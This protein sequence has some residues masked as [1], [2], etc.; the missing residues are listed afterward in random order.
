MS[1]TV[2]AVLAFLVYGVF[3]VL[4]EDWLG[5]L[6]RR[7]TR[8]MGYSGLVV[9]LTVNQI[10][11]AAFRDGL[12]QFSEWSQS[13]MMERYQDLIDAIIANQPDLPKQ[14]APPDPARGE[15]RPIP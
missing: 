9:L 7:V 4:S 2:M 10:S 1:V 8:V 13:R 3:R 14:S 15:M 5:L 12:G 11:P 6:P